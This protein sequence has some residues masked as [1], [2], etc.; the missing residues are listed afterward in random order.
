MAIFRS[1]SQA[2]HFAYLIQAFEVHAESQMATTL[3]RMMQ[4]QLILEIA[5]LQ[6]ALARTDAPAKRRQLQLKLQAL[7]D[8]QGQGAGSTIDIGDLNRLEVRGQCALIRAAVRDHLPSPEKF[9]IEARYEPQ[10]EFH[11]PLENGPHWQPAEGRRKRS[12]NAPCAASRQLNERYWPTSKLAAVTG[13]VRYLQPS[14]GNLSGDQLTLLVARAADRRMVRAGYRELAEMTGVHNSTL[15]RNGVLVRD[16]LV[17][18]E[19][20]AMTR[21]RSVLGDDLIRDD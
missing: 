6:H 10:L 15:A 11:K 8:E 20:Q 3:R 17:G 4:E 12:A 9:A 14:F 1:V 7:I 13:L 5:K 18:L 21:L 16:R 2:V 19:N